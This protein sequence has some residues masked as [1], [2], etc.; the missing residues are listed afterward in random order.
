MLG[1]ARC[2]ALMGRIARLK[3][4]PMASSHQLWRSMM[5][6]TGVQTLLHTHVSR[7]AVCHHDGTRH[8]HPTCLVS[9]APLRQHGHLL[10]LLRHNPD[11]PW[12]FRCAAPMELSQLAVHGLLE[13]DTTLPRNTSNRLES[14]CCL[15]QSHASGLGREGNRNKH[16]APRVA[17]DAQYRRLE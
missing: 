15:R 16:A 14:G 6:T 3:I 4:A 13:M 1:T 17:M 2:T 9:N 5:G 8:H 10:R 7:R 11:A 12:A